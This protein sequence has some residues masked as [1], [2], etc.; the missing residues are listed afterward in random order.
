MHLSGQSQLGGAILSK[1]IKLT[2]KSKLIRWKDYTPP[3]LAFI[4]PFSNCLNPEN[5]QI[6]LS[7]R[8]DESGLD[9][10][11]FALFINNSPL[12]INV[13]EM[14][15]FWHE[16]IANSEFISYTDAIYTLTA[17]V[18][19][20][21]GESIKITRKI[22]IDST[23][24]IIS[25]ISPLNN[26]E[27]SNPIITVSG[28]VHD[29]FRDLCGLVLLVNQKPVMIQ[30]DG[31]WATQ[32]ELVE[33]NNI[34]SA[35]AIDGAGNHS[36]SE[37]NVILNKI[38]SSKLLLPKGNIVDADGNGILEPDEIAIFQPAW[39]NVSTIN[40]S[41]LT[42]KITDFY[43]PEGADYN[44]IKSDALYGGVAPGKTITCS[45][46]NGNCYEVKVSTLQ[47]PLIHW[48]AILQE[49]LS[50]NDV[51]NYLIHIG[52]SFS[53]VNKTNPIYHSAEVLLHH[54]IITKCNED[55]FCP[56]DILKREDLA[57]WVARLL[58]AGEDKIPISGDITGAGIYTYSCQQGGT[59]L[60]EDIEPISIGCKY[61]HFLFSYA[62]KI[63]CN[64][65]PL[66]YCPDDA[67][68]RSDMS[69]FIANA[70]NIRSGDVPIE[71]TDSKTGRSYNCSPDNPNIHFIDVSPNDLWC[72]HAHYLWAIGLDEGCAEGLFCPSTPIT[73]AFMAKILEKAFNL[74]FN[75]KP[76]YYG[77]INMP[78]EV[79]LCYWSPYVHLFNDASFNDDQ[80]NKLINLYKIEGPNYNNRI[81]G[82]RTELGDN[83][84]PSQAEL[85][86]FHNYL[87]RLRRE[88]PGLDILMILH[89][90][91]IAPIR[92]L[93]AQLQ[94][95][96]TIVQQFKDVVHHFEIGNEPDCFPGPT[97]CQDPKRIEPEVYYNNVLKPIWNH[98]K[99]KF[100][101]IH[102][103]PASFKGNTKGMENLKKLIDCDLGLN[104]NCPGE[105][106]IN[107]M[108]V[109]NIHLYCI[110]DFQDCLNKAIEQKNR[111]NSNV[112]M[113][114][115]ETGSKR[116][117][118]PH[119]E[120]VNEHYWSIPASR[121]YW[122][123]FAGRYNSGDE[124]SML[125][126]QGGN[127]AQ[128]DELYTS[129]SSQP[130]SRNAFITANGSEGPI[131][132]DAGD[133]VQLEWSSSNYARSCDVKQ[134][135]FKIAHS[136]SGSRRIEVDSNSIFTL[137]CGFCRE[138]TDE[139]PPIDEVSV[140][141]RGNLAADIKINGQDGYIITTEYPLEI[142]WT[143]TNS[144]E[145]YVTKNGALWANG[146]SG[147]EWDMCSFLQKC[148]YVLTCQNATGSFRDEASALVSEC[149]SDADCSFDEQCN[150]GRCEP[151]T[152]IIKK[153]IL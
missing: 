117:E 153:P 18:N 48:D 49:Q 152:E 95:V 85:N 54:N 62:A 146:I 12:K 90:D 77:A 79:N 17:A 133:E 104:L 142:K 65:E 151:K 136:R 7:A 51:Y 34:I 23:P 27:V 111:L 132:I 137:H 145:C 1:E 129:L 93:E 14:D 101:S 37:I 125:L 96:D 32:V 63:A 52:E 81:K 45:Y 102:F 97:G 141:V 143:S 2:G 36:T 8:D 118:Q 33:G 108:G 107:Q 82:I 61:V 98:V 73:R 31:S 11:S 38:I 46:Q 86:Y 121:I 135:G 80:K 140:Y 66:K 113:W 26:I 58:A 122:F 22:I 105:N 60:F 41:H 15:S 47:R 123:S 131:T 21:A 72:A 13:N 110:S 127:L 29:S 28:T 94:Y 40:V 116:R 89:M 57:I 68:T 112:Q 55:K 5:N 84:N 100:P 24:P 19:N 147:F 88:A 83:C 109:L 148:T 42:G 120:Y 20:R 50:T 150:K 75:P 39:A 139:T 115:T 59:S 6:I 128:V 126:Y 67:A 106:I 30:S 4:Q 149:L 119:N 53:D 25:I 99:T 56:D 43:G 138:V 16:A 87:S 71:Y 78:D 9:P 44:L 69:I 76:S 74:D 3:S 103:I 124:Y 92:G 134:N 10:E 130:P 114:V 35:T 91:C 70:L 64:S 144:S